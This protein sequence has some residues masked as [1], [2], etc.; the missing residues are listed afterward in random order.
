MSRK[1]RGEGVNLPIE[2]GEQVQKHDDR[3]NVKIQFPHQLRF[4]DGVNIF[5]LTFDFVVSQ[6]IGF[7]VF[8]C[9][10]EHARFRR[11]E[12]HGHFGF[13]TI[14]CNDSS[15]VDDSAWALKLG[16]VYGGTEFSK[17]AS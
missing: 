2:K 12:G 10:S 8:C 3:Y 17:E 14:A 15:P 4:S 9:T 16:D 7:V 6:S 11:G 13:W 5:Q 1:A